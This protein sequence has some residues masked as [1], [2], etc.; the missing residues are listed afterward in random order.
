MSKINFILHFTH[1][2]LLQLNFQLF[3]TKLIDSIIILPNEARVQQWI[4]V[5]RD[6]KQL[7]LR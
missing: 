1:P 7:R 2:L 4:S 5:Q 3:F 6:R